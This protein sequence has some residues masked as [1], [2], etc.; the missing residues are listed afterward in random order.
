[1]RVTIDLELNNIPYEHNIHDDIA[2]LQLYLQE[3]YD[4]EVEIEI[5]DLDYVD[6]IS[7]AKA[8]HPDR[9]A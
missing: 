8:I 1:M 5:D 6:R 3:L 4:T 2:Y 7:L 9:N